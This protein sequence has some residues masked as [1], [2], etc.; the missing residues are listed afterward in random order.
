MS[1]SSPSITFII[2][3]GASN[4][5]GMPTGYHLKSAIANALSFYVDE[6]RRLAGGDSTIRECLYKLAQN[7][8]GALDVNVFLQAAHLINRAMPQAPSID[9]FIDSHRSNEQIADVGKLAIAA[10]I[11]KAEKACK[12]FVDQRNVRN[13]IP[14]NEV[15]DTWF[16]AFFQL[17]TLNAQ[18]SDISE[19]FRAV[20]I[21]TFNYDRTLEHY[22]HQALQNYYGCTGDEAAAVLA[23]L[24]VLHPYGQVGSLP[25]QRPKTN[26][27]PF[28]ASLPT[29]GLLAVARSLR[30]FTEGTNTQTSNVELIRA[31]VSESAKLVFLGFGYH[32]LNLEVLFGQG[33]DGAKRYTNEVYGTAKGLSESNKKA[34]TSELASLGKF[35]ESL[36]TL[37]NQL[38]AAALFSEYSRSLKI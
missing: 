34:I 31:S 33:I 23:D 26:A 5:V 27:V 19:R 1:Q 20:R 3:A 4:E 18:F 25:W 16:N 30:T 32:E 28:G 6:F 37:R 29:E 9:N 24:V 35:D 11:L 2:G 21:I 7:S 36:I 38:T 22:L 17:I 10:E 14:F 13:E 12:L 8:S 15:D